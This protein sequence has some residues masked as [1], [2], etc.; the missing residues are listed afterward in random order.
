M[1]YAVE[2]SDGRTLRTQVSIDPLWKS[3]DN[4]S[5]ADRPISPLHVPR[6]LLSDDAEFDEL[7]GEIFERIEAGSAPSP[8]EYLQRY[9]QFADELTEFFRNQAW[10]AAPALAETLADDSEPMVAASFVGCEVGPYRLIEEIARGG[11]GVVY[12]ALQTELNREVAVKLISSGAMAS[13]EELRRFR[14]EA[15]AA[16]QLHHPNIV[17]IYDVGSWRGQTYFSMTLIEGESLQDWVAS[18]RCT[19]QQAVVAVREIAHAVSYAHRRGIVHRDLK[20]ANILVDGEGKPM[21]TD[22][23]LAKWH[24]DGSALTQTGQILGT[25]NYMSPEQASGSTKI[26]P[27]ADI[28]ALG[29]VLYSLLTGQPPH[30]GESTVEIL[31]KVLG[32]DPVPPRELNREVSSDLQRICMECLNHDPKERY[33]TAAELADDLDRYLNGDSISAGHSGMFLELARTLRRDQH[34]EH[35]RNWGKALVLMGLSIF[36]A[37]VAIF[38]LVRR[39]HSDWAAYWTPRCYM[40]V[41]LTAVIYYYRSGTLRARSVAERPI[42]SIW[43]GYLVALGTMNAILTL[44]GTSQV[45]VFPF[46]STLAAFG[47]VALGGHVW[48]GS[49][50]LGGLFVVNALVSVFIGQWAILSFGACWLLALAVLAYRYRKDAAS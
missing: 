21:L 20:P 31:T 13:P 3:V 22:F 24:R 48:G 44:R 29:A 28:Y 46:A 30:C 12:R 23:G 17:P 37:H 35:F 1:A 14:Q 4:G 34:Y 47:F 49:Y 6:T 18:R 39:G 45:E 10:F 8:E 15:E 38:V 26:G 50:L 40:A 36:L 33:A 19:I 16:A 41:A 27:S 5:H 42:W 43:M 32:C 9:P 25:P 2:P 7:L 11:M